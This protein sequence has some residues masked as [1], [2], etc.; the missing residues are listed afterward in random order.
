MVLKWTCTK[1]LV[2]NGLFNWHPRPTSPP[3][4][5]PLRSMLHRFVVVVCYLHGLQMFKVEKLKNKQFHLLCTWKLG[6][7]L[8]WILMNLSGCEQFNFVNHSQPIPYTFPL[9][10]FLLYSVH[11]FQVHNSPA[12]Y[13]VIFAWNYCLIQ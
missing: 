9:S 13:Y 11:T 3:Y 7:I 1:K 8:V 4:S 2:F 12:V 10:T 5:Q 6:W